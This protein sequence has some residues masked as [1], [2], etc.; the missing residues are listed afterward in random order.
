MSPT[1]YLIPSVL[2]IDAVHT[3]SEEN[4]NILKELKVFFVEDLR[5]ARRFLKKVHRDIVIDEL[6]FYLINEHESTDIQFAEKHFK[7]GQSIGLLSD[8]GTPAIADPGARLVARAHDLDVRVKPIS[9]PNSIML[10][11]MASGFNGQ[12]FK[13]NGYIPVKDPKRKDVIRALEDESKRKNITQIFIEAPYR[14]EQLKEALLK[15][16]KAETQLSISCNLTAAD[17]IIISKKVKD[18]PAANI[19]IHKK[20]AV[21]MLYCAGMG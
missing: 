18:W 16:L 6:T 3:L 9:G 19:N 14:N 20:P 8:C 2:E 7:D 12:Q 10:A 21:F 4:K 5:T 15:T 11:L 1:L 13:F 17:E